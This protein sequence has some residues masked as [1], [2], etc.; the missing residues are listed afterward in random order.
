[1]KSKSKTLKFIVII[2]LIALTFIYLMPIYVMVTN[3]L[4]TLP[5]ITQRTYLALPSNPQIKNYTSAL[6]GSKDFLIPMARPF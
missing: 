2:V 3:S 1:M 4:K 5:E 6:F